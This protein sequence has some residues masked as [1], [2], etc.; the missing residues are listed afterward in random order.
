[1]QSKTRYDD[2][3][4]QTIRP[5]DPRASTQPDDQG[6]DDG[7]PVEKD[8]HDRDESTPSQHKD[9]HGQDDGAP[10]SGPDDQ[11]RDDS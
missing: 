6:R 4:V 7:A 11:G 1:M 5:G 3:D 2:A 9:V 8:T 10:A